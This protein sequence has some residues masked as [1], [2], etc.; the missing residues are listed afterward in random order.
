MGVDYAQLEAKMMRIQEIKDT[1][2]KL[3]WE[4]DALMGTVQ[5]LLTESGGFQHVI[6]L[7]DNFEIIVQIKETSKKVF[8]KEA[9]A[10]DLGVTASATTR[11]DFLINMT[12][13]RKLTLEKFKKYFHHEPN[14]AMTFRKKA[15]PKKRRKKK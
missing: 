5:K 10:D 1:R 12:E 2:K 7:D 9:M 8:E 11:K 14:T 13:Q 4:E 3:K 6:Q 15:I